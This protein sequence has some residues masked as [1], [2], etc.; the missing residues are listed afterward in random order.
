MEKQKHNTEAPLL[1][2]GLDAAKNMFGE[3]LNSKRIFTALQVASVMGILMNPA[4]AKEGYDIVDVTYDGKTSLYRMALNEGVTVDEVLSYNPGLNPNAMQ[5]GQ[6]IKMPMKIRY[7]EPITQVQEVKAHP[8]ATPLIEDPYA[9]GTG[10]IPY[11]YFYGTAEEQD[12]IYCEEN[13][14]ACEPDYA[15]APQ[16]VGVDATLASFDIAPMPEDIEAKTFYDLVKYGEKVEFSEETFFQFFQ[17]ALDTYQNGNRRADIYVSYNR[18]QARSETGEKYIDALPAIFEKMGRAPWE[19]MITVVETGFRDVR[20]KAGAKG[21]NQFL[22]DTWKRYKPFKGASVHNALHSAEGSANYL[23][24]LEEIYGKAFAA[25]SAYNGGYMKQYQRQLEE[26]EELTLG[27]FYE[28]MGDRVNQFYD[29]LQTTKPYRVPKTMKREDLATL[30][31]ISEKDIKR[32]NK[33][34]RT[35]KKGH[36]LLVP[37]QAKTP[38]FKTEGKI[39]R[40][41]K[42]DTYF[43][44]SKQYKQSVENL[45]AMNKGKKFWPGEE[46][47]VS[48]DVDDID[49]FLD[50]LRE[51]TFYTKLRHIKENTYYLAKVIAVNATFETGMAKQIWEEVNTKRERKSNVRLASAER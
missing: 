35:Y 18:L 49:E 44:L 24:T 15:E 37:P 22:S 36:V 34:R 33:V 41:K 2:R 23:N 10:H 47:T 3:V 5:K 28:Y 11:A 21:Y 14:P 4:L 19:S 42:G 13:H 30:L 1:K 12:Q 50:Q 26:G 40:L 29:A 51:D 48:L 8:V 6:K 45:K 43:S 39:H 32:F 25:Y 17:H 31:G 9:E 46:I 7:A 16:E 20:S 27:G 38:E